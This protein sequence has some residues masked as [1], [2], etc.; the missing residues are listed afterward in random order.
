MAL[1]FLEPAL[2]HEAIELFP[3]DNGSGVVLAS[4]KYRGR[5]GLGNPTVG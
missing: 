2:S 1:L 5:D 3:L 4:G